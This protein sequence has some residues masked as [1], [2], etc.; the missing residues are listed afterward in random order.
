MSSDPRIDQ[1]LLDWHSH[2]SALGHKPDEFQHELLWQKSEEHRSH[3][4]L[5]LTAPE[6]SYVLKKHFI[7]GDVEAVSNAQTAAQNAL[8][9]HTDAVVPKIVIAD[10]KS[11]L[12]VMEH[13]NGQTINEAMN[14]ENDPM[15]I[16]RKIAIWCNAF[17]RN[18]FDETRIFRPVFMSRFFEKM[19]S[20]IK[21]GNRTVPEP[22]AYLRCASQ[23]TDI[24]ERYKNQ[25]TK[26]AQLHGDLNVR[27]FL[28]G[29]AQTAALDFKPF[30]IKPSGYDIA[31]VLLDFTELFG[32]PNAVAVGD[33]VPQDIKD[34]FF[35]EYKFLPET[36]PAI[37]FLCYTRLLEDWHSIPTNP[38]HRSVR[39]EYRLEQIL[40]IAELAFEL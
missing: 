1:A 3:I 29:E 24:A 34:A 25:E 14:D 5:K 23:I 33:V 11:E 2:A 15:E 8:A 17:H 40:K 35:S 38:D 6:Q 37:S 7:G 10:P 21:E 16:V 20:S 13:F 4:V 31:R 26:T 9:D 28:F 19:V 39:Q 36:D 32:D 30:D 18:S 27:N 22:Q 12:L